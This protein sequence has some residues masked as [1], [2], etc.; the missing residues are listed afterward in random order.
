MNFN[1]IKDKHSAK[2]FLRDALC[3]HD[4]SD[5]VWGKTIAA[6]KYQIVRQAFF[7]VHMYVRQQLKDRHDI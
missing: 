6:I 1:E 5:L 3:Y 7:E 2:S 4:V